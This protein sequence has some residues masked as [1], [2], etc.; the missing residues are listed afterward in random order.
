MKIHQKNTDNHTTDKSLRALGV[1]SPGDKDECVT[2]IT[3]I[4]SK[5]AQDVWSF[6]SEMQKNYI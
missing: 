4:S 1:L 5:T 6:Q 2:S 3:D